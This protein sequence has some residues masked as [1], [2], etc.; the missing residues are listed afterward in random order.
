M[1]NDMAYLYYR[2]V[3]YMVFYMEYTLFYGGAIYVRCY[4]SIILE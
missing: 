4:D 3:F 1:W 2:C